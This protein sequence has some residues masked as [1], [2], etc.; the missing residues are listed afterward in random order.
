MISGASLSYALQHITFSM[1][2]LIWKSV[3]KLQFQYWKV[4]FKGILRYNDR[5][6]IPRFQGTMHSSVLRSDEQLK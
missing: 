5:K 3:A 4:C 2:Q 6:L 1:S